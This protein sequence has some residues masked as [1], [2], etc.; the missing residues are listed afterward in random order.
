MAVSRN[1][2]WSSGA[3]STL[4]HVNP[5]GNKRIMVVAFCAESST[6]ADVTSVDYG[7]Q[8]L[9]PGPERTE[10]AGAAW[11]QMEIWYLLE[12]GIAAATNTTITPTYDVSL[13]RE[14]IAAATFDDVDQTTPVPEQNTDGTNASTPNPLTGADIVEAI[15]NAIVAAGGNGQGT[16]DPPSGVTW[17]SPMMEQ[18]ELT[19]DSNAITTA[20][21]LSI[22]DAN[23][24]I[25]PTWASQNRSTLVSIELAAAA[26]AVVDAFIPAGGHMGMN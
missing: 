8:A 12:A 21:R 7:G 11:L 23:V 17:N 25:E 5:P 20:D 10:G 1:G 24:D 6:T 19:T 9:T 14:I 4:T 3:A 18:I 15:G 22:T 26:V 2:A 13:S 16:D